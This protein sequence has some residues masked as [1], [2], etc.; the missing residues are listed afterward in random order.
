VTLGRKKP[1][2]SPRQPRRRRWGKPAPLEV[3]LEL[4]RKNPA[5]SIRSE[6]ERKKHRLL[7]I[8]ALHLGP[9]LL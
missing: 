5:D 3:E 9:R 4:P 7:L 8:R 6:Q 1:P 2:P